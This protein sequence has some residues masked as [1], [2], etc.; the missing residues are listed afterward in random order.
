MLD[1]RR[2][3]LDMGTI[4]YPARGYYWRCDLVGRHEYVSSNV[5][6]Y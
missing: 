4:R 3:V 1:A 6:W 5:I 2:I